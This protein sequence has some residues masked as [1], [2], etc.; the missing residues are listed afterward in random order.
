LIGLGSGL[1]QPTLS[2]PRP[3]ATA[4]PELRFG[5]L[6]E[7]LD[8]L[9]MALSGASQRLVSL[10]QLR[11]QLRDGSAQKFELGA[12]LV[13]QFNAPIPR[14]IGLSHQS[15]FAVRRGAPAFELER[16]VWL[17]SGGVAI[18]QGNV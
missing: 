14:L 12:L 17:A 1:Q 7:C 4:A 10:I 8:C 2:Q 11:A 13:A 15:L 5:E 16:R 3:N 9:V 6:P 18:L